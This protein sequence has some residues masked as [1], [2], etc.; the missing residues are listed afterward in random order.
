[1]KFYV[2]FLSILM[3]LGMLVTI[4][5]QSASLTSAKIYIRQNELDLA[6]EQLELTTKQ[7]SDNAEAFYWLGY[8]C[9]EQGDYECMNLGFDRAM[10]L[11][12]NQY[13][14]DI[15]ST[16]EKHWVKY[17]NLGVNTFKAGDFNS[18]IKYFQIAVTIDPKK[19][20]AFKNL[21]ASYFRTNDLEKAIAN[22]DKAASVD[23]SDSRS[24]DSIGKI[25][26]NE[27]ER[28]KAID[29]WERALRVDPDDIEILLELGM[30]YEAATRADDALDLYSRASKLDPNNGDV[31]YNIG[32]IY[33]NK[34]QHD[35]AIRY[36][37]KAIEVD[38]NDL[39]ASFNLGVTYL[40]I[41]RYDDALPLFIKVSE[42]EPGTD[43]DLSENEMKRIKQ[44]SWYNLGIVY[45]RKDMK[46]ESEAAFAKAEELKD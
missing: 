37:M 44:K 29:Y 26:F 19:A 2:H 12:P 28:E 4:G 17:F 35:E 42:S 21:A 1:M 5:C 14:N 45:A 13:S 9:S 33:S 40:R 3:V 27:G 7:E 23:P 34:D 16:R 24:L 18:S 38:P 39:E 31:F 20:D 22:Y 6:R 36:Y 25:Y 11:K 10:E 41:E 15:A 43:E 30:A 8:V 32:V 46:A